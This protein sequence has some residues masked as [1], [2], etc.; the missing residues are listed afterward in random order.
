[1]S[2]V[3]M[4]RLCTVSDGRGGDCRCRVRVATAVNIAAAEASRQRISP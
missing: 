2:R 1:V 3:A 4:I